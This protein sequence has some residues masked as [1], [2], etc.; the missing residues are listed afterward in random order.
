M[1]SL[2]MS[3]SPLIFA[4]WVAL[5]I[6]FGFLNATAVVLCAIIVAILAV[7][8]VKFCVEHFDN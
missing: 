7:L 6:C 4:L 3:L 8:W 5:S 1:K 2:F